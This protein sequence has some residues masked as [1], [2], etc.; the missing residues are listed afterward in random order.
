MTSHCLVIE[1]RGQRLKNLFYALESGKMEYQH[2]P[3]RSQITPSTNP[4]NP[5]KMLAVANRVN[6]V[7]DRP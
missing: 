7:P 1:K 2:L 5:I 4:Y 3:S 6:C